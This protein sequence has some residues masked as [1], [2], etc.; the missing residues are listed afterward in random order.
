MKPVTSQDTKWTRLQTTQGP[1][2]QHAK[3]RGLGCLPMRST[4][5]R[6]ILGAHGIRRLK[7][8]LMAKVWLLKLWA[9]TIPSIWTCGRP[10]SNKGARRYGPRNPCCAVSPK[11]EPI[12]FQGRF[13][14]YLRFQGKKRIP[15]MKIISWHTTWTPIWNIWSPDVGDMAPARKD[16][17]SGKSGRGWFYGNQ[18][19]LSPKEDLMQG[20]VEHAPRH[21]KDINTTP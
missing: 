1:K 3:L 10:Y 18:V 11:S 12:I 13:G 16:C 7:R 17:E 2:H 21:P 6:D 15:K 20:K 19:C 4:Q 5:P 8:P 9:S 14:S